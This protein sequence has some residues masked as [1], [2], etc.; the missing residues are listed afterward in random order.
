MKNIRF[1]ILLLSIVSSNISAGVIYLN[2]N[3]LAL[4]KQTDPF[5]ETKYDI[6][7][8]TRNEFYFSCTHINMEVSSEYELYDSF[9]YDTE[10]KFKV[11]DYPVISKEGNYSTYH[12]GKKLMTDSRYYSLAINEEDL[13]LLF[14]GKSLKFAGKWGSWDTKEVSLKGFKQAYFEMCDN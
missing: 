14:K 8:I 12:N 7:K 1:S 2:D 13:E 6:I 9:S 11:D 3:W 5:D 4:T 10:I